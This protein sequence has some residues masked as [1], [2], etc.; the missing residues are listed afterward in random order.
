MEKIAKALEKPKTKTLSKKK[1]SMPSHSDIYQSIQK[2][3][4]FFKCK[5]NPRNLEAME[6]VRKT[7]MSEIENRIYDLAAAA[8][9]KIFTSTPSRHHMPPLEALKKPYGKPIPPTPNT[10]FAPCKDPCF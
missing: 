4:T 6:E 1:A 7:G 10:S 9:W 3:E 8:W 2:F 5:W